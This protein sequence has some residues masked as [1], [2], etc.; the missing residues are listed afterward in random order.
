MKRFSL[1]F[2]LLSVV[3][4][5]APA[6]PPV[7]P[8]KS[9]GQTLEPH[10]IYLRV[11]AL[12]EDLPATPLS[13]T[14]SLVLDL[15]FVSAGPDAA[16]AFATWLNA[17]SRPQSP[18]LVLINRETSP[19]LL[20]LLTTPPLPAGM[21]S[22][23]A[24]APGVRPDIALILAADA[25]RTAYEAL[26]H[27]TPLAELI[28]PKLDKVRHDEAAMA[29]ERAAGIN[30]ETDEELPLPSPDDEKAKS[31]ATVAPAPPVDRVLQRAVQLHH[32][33]QALGKIR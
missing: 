18:V 9:A 8:P 13:A 32:A 1:F 6:V 17:R 14:G 15:R 10:L 5:A 20:T 21:V 25:D 22:L 7:T 31:P 11:H 27:G 16:S 19:A 28:N 33:L 23:G 26:E 4:R 24:A 3:L 12:P 29:R 30:S 2:I